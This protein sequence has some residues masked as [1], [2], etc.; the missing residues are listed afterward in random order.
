MK[1]YLDRTNCKTWESPCESCFSSHYLGDEIEP[2][3]C[4]VKIEDDHQP[5]RTFIIEDRDGVE[6]ILVVDENNWA[7][8]HDSWMMTWEQVEAA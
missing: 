8:V 6:K 5:A 3:Y 4:L 1:V 7:A 2:N